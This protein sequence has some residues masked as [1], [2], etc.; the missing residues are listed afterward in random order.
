HTP[1]IVM[2]IAGL[3]NGIMDPLLIFGIG[4]FPELGIRGAAIATV[5]SWALSALAILVILIHKRRLMRIADIF[6][7]RRTTWA[8]ILHLA[9]P[10]SATN[11]M[12]PIT[13]MV[14]TAM[15]ATLGHHAVAGFGVGTRIEAISL[16]IIIALSSALAP[17]VG[18]NYGAGN[19]MRIRESLRYTLSFALGC[20]L[21]IA[22]V[23]YLNGDFVADLF[24]EQEQTKEAI[25]WYLLLVPLS[26]GCQGLVMLSCST[27]NAM[28][29][30]LYGTL[31]SVF[32]LFVLTIPLAWLGSHWFQAAGLYGGVA[33][34][35]VI[36]GVSAVL[37]LIYRLPQLSVNH[38]MLA[39]SPNQLSK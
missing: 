21:L 1:S 17:F 13:A 11:L 26:Y 25:R 37:W 5:M 9:I 7:K 10:A 24:T 14:L 31:I 6:G 12:M 19:S 38:E 35:N 20:E 4:P 23:L 18:Q 30:P 8:A 36:A 34:A 3:V 22:A 29:R 39:Q 27:L 16:V 15:A 28:H 2:A 32:R 33:V